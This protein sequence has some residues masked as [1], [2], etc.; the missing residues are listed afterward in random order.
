[1]HVPAGTKEKIMGPMPEGNAETPEDSDTSWTAVV[2]G[3]AALS[4]GTQK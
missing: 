1:M 3:M 2:A 4:W